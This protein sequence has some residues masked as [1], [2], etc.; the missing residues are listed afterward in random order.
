MPL[1]SYSHP[2]LISLVCVIQLPFSFH[3]PLF[4][5]ILCW[6][7][8]PSFRCTVCMLYCDIFSLTSALPC[9]SF[10]SR[11]L[12]FVYICGSLKVM[13]LN[14]EE[15]QLCDWLSFSL[16]FR[17]E[18]KVCLGWNSLMFYSFPVIFQRHTP[19]LPLRHQCLFFWSSIFV[20]RRQECVKVLKGKWWEE[21]EERLNERSNEEQQQDGKGSKLKDRRGDSLRLLLRCRCCRRETKNGLSS[22]PK[23]EERG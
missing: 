10:L 17:W 21:M 1:V 12:C 20:S 13:S 2:H 18:G 19:F 23:T 6:I 11:S 5:K 14:V 7:F 9:L 22:L 4:P 16:Y 8:H 15:S 3:M